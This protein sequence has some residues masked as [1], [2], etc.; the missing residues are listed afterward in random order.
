MDA[1]GSHGC[2]H[3]WGL[4]LLPIVDLETPQRLA[5]SAQGEDGLAD[6][7]EGDRLSWKQPGL[8]LVVSSGKLT[9]RPLWGGLVQRPGAQRPAVIKLS[10]LSSRH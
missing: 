4:L 9:S 10:G 1:S 5:S 2:P 8:L 3:G 7:V 6:Q